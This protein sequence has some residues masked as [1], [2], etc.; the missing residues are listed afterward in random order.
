M[1]LET[2]IDVS[3]FDNSD[4][5]V[6]YRFAIIGG[7][8]TGTSLLCQLVDELARMGEAGRLFGSRLGIDVFEKGAE[9]GPGLPHSSVYV[10]P[11]H[12]TNMCARDMTVRIAS[13]DDFQQWVGSNKEVLSH[14]FDQSEYDFSVSGKVDEHC[15]HYP[16]EVMGEYL[17][18]QLDDAAQRAEEIGIEVKIWRR[19]EVVDLWGEKTNIYLTVVEDQQGRKRVGSFQGALL[20]TG[21]WFESSPIDN[22]FTS[23]WPASKLLKAIPPGA[24]V[25]GVGSSL[26]AIET[27]LTLSAEG[28]FHRLSSGRLRYEK[29]DEPRRLTLFSRQGL[30]PRVRGRIGSRRNRYFTCERLQRLM[31]E[32]PNQ[33]TLMELFHLLDQELSAAYEAPIDWQEILDPS[34]SPV[35]ILR[36]DIDRAVKGDGSE[37]ELVWQ[38]V[39]VQIFPVVRELYLSLSRAERQRFD[40]EFNTLFFIHA[41]TQPAINAEKLLALMEAGIVKVK[42]LGEDYRFAWNESSGKFEFH[43]TGPDGHT[44]CDI[45]PYCVDARGQP[46]SIETD[47][48]ELTRNLLKRGIVQIEQ[49]HLAGGQHTA[50]PITGSILIDP[51]THLVVQPRSGNGGTPDVQLFAVGAMTRGQII[52]SSMAYGLARSTAAVAENLISIHKIMDSQQ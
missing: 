25:G 2:A 19:C 33:L 52:D 41:A 37:G 7:G 36:Q 30:L 29:P 16:R 38:T 34:E 11:F 26:S 44:L 45:F 27:A 20:A 9:V 3:D 12:I 13:P 22:Y 15:A 4:Y 47:S 43:Y 46:R 24:E 17:K 8:L 5:S 51:D 42:K 40:R 14:C 6:S 21:H 49:R 10:L 31:D 50:S 48:S 18:N 28:R 39:L 23:P 35:H 1:G 32:R